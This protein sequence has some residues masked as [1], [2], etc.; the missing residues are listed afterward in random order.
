MQINFKGLDKL[1]KALNPDNAKKEMLSTATIK[2]PSCKKDIKV[3][4]G[5]NI[6]P[7]CKANID[8]SI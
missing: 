1:S 3:K 7:F 6:C 4:L 5:N 2:C 8:Y